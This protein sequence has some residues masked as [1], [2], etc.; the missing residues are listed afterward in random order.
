KKIRTDSQLR[1]TLKMLHK[2]GLSLEEIDTIDPDIFNALFIYYTL[3]EPNLARMEMIKYANLCNLLLMTSQ[4]I[5]PEARKKAKVSDW[6]FADLL[7]DVSLTMREKA[8]KR[9]EQEIENS[10]NNIKSIG[11]MIKRQISNEGKNGKKK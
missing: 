10:R 1:F 7:S 9:E 2:R 11:D 5:T 8:L 3:I 4:S 6:D